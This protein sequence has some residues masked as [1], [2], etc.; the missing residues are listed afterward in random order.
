MI[1]KFLPVAMNFSLFPHP[2]EL[3]ANFANDV[4]ENNSVVFVGHEI[5]F[6]KMYAN[7]TLVLY[8][9]GDVVDISEISRPLYVTS[10]YIENEN[11]VEFKELMKLPIYGFFSEGYSSYSTI[12]L[13]SKTLNVTD[14]QVKAEY[15]GYKRDM[16]DTYEWLYSIR[17]NILLKIFT[18][19]DFPQLEYK[20]YEL[21]A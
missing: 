4:V 11:E 3:Y 15:S 12:V 19:Y 1:L 8:G 17:G 7:P 10:Q 6:Y 9:E 5:P 20:I 14:L 18:S 21:K 13:G 2:H 16:E